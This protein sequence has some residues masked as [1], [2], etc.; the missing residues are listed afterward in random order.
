MSAPAIPTHMKNT[1]NVTCITMGTNNEQ[2]GAQDNNSEKCPNRML[3]CGNT[4]INNGL[5][6]HQ[7]VIFANKSLL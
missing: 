5:F 3:S 7:P 6:S 2:S 4:H 1:N